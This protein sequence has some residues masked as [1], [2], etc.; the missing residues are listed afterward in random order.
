[1]IP[2]LHLHDHLGKAYFNYRNLWNAGFGAT[3]VSLGS[4]G[5]GLGNLRLEQVFDLRG[6]EYILDKNFSQMPSGPYGILT[7]RENITDHY[8]VE[9]KRIGLHPSQYAK[10]LKGIKGFPK[11]NFEESLL[12]D[13]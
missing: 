13:E 2:G 1:M 10:S 3:D 9:A 11:D 5:K 6:R 7:A 12:R 8:A 4:I